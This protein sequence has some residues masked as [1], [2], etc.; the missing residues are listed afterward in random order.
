[1]TIKISADPATYQ[2]EC[3]KCSWY[4]NGVSLG[5]AQ[6]YADAHNKEFHNDQ[7]DILRFFTGHR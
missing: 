1:M 5:E 3:E 6:A 4:G 2:F 7:E